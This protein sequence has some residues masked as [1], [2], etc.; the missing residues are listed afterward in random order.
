M[1]K[2]IGNVIFFWL[3]LIAQGCESNAAI[4]SLNCDGIQGKQCSDI[5]QYCDLGVG[6]CNVPGNGGA[7]KDKPKVCTKQYAPVCGCDGNTYG[8]ACEAASA[9]ITLKYKGECNPP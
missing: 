1:K 2:L 8:N 9:G 7:C 5:N 3:I 6:Q 4:R